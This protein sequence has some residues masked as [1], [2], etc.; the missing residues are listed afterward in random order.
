[1][2]ADDERLRAWMHTNVCARIDDTADDWDGVTCD[3]LTARLLDGPLRQ[4]IAERDKARAQVQRVE[5]LRGQ[6]MRDGSAWAAI[7]LRR[8][9]DGGS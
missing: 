1:M 4:L 8:A 7:H 9:L 2:G 5:E 6:W 3:D